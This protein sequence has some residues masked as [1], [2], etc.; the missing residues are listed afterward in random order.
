[1]R[2]SATAGAGRRRNRGGGTTMGQTGGEGMNDMQAVREAASRM[3]AG[4]LEHMYGVC[5]E[6]IPQQLRDDVESVARDYLDLTDPTPLTV[7]RLLERGYARDAIRWPGRPDVPCL[8]RGRLYVYS[9][10]HADPRNWTW[11]HDDDGPSIWPVPRTVGE[12]AM[13]EHLMEG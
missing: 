10:E 5:I 13:I 1:M 8:R 11:E 7:E 4:D 9:H 3:V 6:D 12:L 2:L